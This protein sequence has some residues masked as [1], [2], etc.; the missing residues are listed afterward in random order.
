[1]YATP[2]VDR[3][4]DRIALDVQC[5]GDGTLPVGPERCGLTMWY[6]HDSE[7]TEPNGT[8]HRYASCD[9][10]HSWLYAGTGSE[11]DAINLDGVVPGHLEDDTKGRSFFKSAGP[12]ATVVVQITSPPSR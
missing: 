4:G 6:S 8:F 11:R 3:N 1:M 9:N 2:A 10:G 12:R 5:N 7:P